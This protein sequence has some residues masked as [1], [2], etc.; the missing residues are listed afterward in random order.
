MVGAIA[1][2]LSVAGYVH[3]SPLLENRLNLFDTCGVGNLHGIPALV[4]GIA[5]IV[6]V[7]MNSDE[8]FLGYEAG[9][10]MGRQAAAVAATFFLA[11]LSGFGTGKLMALFHDEEKDVYNDVTWWK[12][13]YFEASCHSRVRDPSV[14]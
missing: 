12:T 5:S 8:E 10:Q 1:G 7:S 2:T 11:L 3:V 13:E 4:G 14:H 9:E 6:F